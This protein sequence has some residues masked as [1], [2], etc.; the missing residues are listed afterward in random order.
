MENKSFILKVIIALIFLLFIIPYVLVLS[1]RN[2][3]LYGITSVAVLSM[4]SAGV[5]LTF[6]ME[7]L[8]LVK[9]HMR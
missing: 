2:D 3:Y 1:G 5:W 9:V 6:Y 8:I 4:I 7:E